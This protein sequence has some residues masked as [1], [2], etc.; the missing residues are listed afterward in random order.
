MQKIINE[1]SLELGIPKMVILNTYKAYW[2]Y[3]KDSIS[4]I[5]FN[6]INSEQEYNKAKVNFNIPNLGK[7]GCTYNRLLRIKQQNKY[8]DEAKHKK[9]KANV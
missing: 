6:Q 1:L 4:K 2:R 8:K 9:D 7:L 3:I 5:D